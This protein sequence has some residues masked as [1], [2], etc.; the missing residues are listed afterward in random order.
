MLISFYFAW[1]VVAISLCCVTAS[2]ETVF[3][4]MD[5]NTDCQLRFYEQVKQACLQDDP[6]SYINCKVDH[7]KD[8]R[9]TADQ[10]KRGSWLGTWETRICT[11]YV[12]FPTTVYV[13]GSHFCRGP[14]VGKT[15]MVKGESVFLVSGCGEFGILQQVYLPQNTLRG[16]SRYIRS[17]QQ[18]NAASKAHTL[19]AG[20]PKGT[21][22]GLVALSEQG[23]GQP[24]LLPG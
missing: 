18:I 12:A 22:W 10:K 7:S 14:C 16:K 24:S 23:P 4:W 5:V 2:E 21:Q 3:N 13:H 15:G 9:R 6:Q 19:H 20:R 11:G 1:L 8:W 17:G